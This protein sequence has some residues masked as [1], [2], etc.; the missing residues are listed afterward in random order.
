MAEYI[1]REAL[2]KKIGD[3]YDL[4]YG[5]ILT[6]PQK[7]FGMVEDAPAADVVPVVH[8]RWVEKEEPYFDII[9]DCSVCGESFCFIEGG[10]SENLYKYCPNCGADMRGSFQNGNNHTKDW[11]SYMDLPREQERKAGETDG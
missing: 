3:E 5:E 1:A 10:P 8:G 11:P 2:L 7:F 6:D 9:Y 4:N